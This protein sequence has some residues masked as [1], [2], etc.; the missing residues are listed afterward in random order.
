MKLSLLYVGFVM[1][2]SKNHT[3]ANQSEFVI[4]VLSF[5]VITVGV[6]YLEGISFCSSQEPS[7]WY[8]ETS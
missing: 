4:L 2:K 5:S 1:A 6:L 3:N 8:K 7:K